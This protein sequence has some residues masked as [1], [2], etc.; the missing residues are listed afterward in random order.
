MIFLK[1]CNILDGLGLREDVHLLTE[2]G[3]SK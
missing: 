2:V 1:F 3:H